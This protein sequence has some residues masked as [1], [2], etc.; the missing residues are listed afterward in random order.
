MISSTW[1][2]VCIVSILI[3][4][5]FK[6]FAHRNAV[7]DY[8]PIKKV[9]EVSFSWENFKENHLK[10]GVPVIVVASNSPYHDPKKATKNPK[11][12]PSE[13][14]HEVPPADMFRNVPENMLM[15]CG[16][17]RVSY[18]N[19]INNKTGFVSF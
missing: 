10:T 14:L 16:D 4:I 2:I 5:Y 6:I 3:G 11:R 12:S 17:V 7:D 19:K 1:K 18:S 15:Q 8:T 9:N 13:S